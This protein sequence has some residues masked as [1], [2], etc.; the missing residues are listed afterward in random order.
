MKYSYSPPHG[1]HGGPPL[2]R[3]RS[4]SPP[5]PLSHPSTQRFKYSPP[6]SRNQATPTSRYKS[7]QLT[8]HYLLK[9]FLAPYKLTLQWSLGVPH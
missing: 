8:K 5:P 4:K 3:A 6:P 9:Y 1:S 7:Y 2:Q